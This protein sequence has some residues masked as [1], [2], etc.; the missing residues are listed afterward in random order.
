MSMRVLYTGTLL[1]LG[2]GYIFALLYVFASH[3][4]RDGQPGISVQDIIITY[5]GTT[6]GTQLESALRGPMSL[7]IQEDERAKVISWIR[8]GAEK[9]EYEVIIKPIIESECLACHDGRNPHLSNLDG[10]EN[11]E[12]VI[13]QDTGADLYSL[14][15]VSHIHLFG[16]TFIFFIMGLIFSHAYLRPVWFK[17]TVIVTPLVCIVADVSSWYITKLY[18]PFGWVVL[19]AGGFMG[20]S[21]AFMWF[22]SMYQMWFFK[23]PEDLRLRMNERVRVIG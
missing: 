9:S 20:L 18:N 22:V 11:M 19:V 21:F 5:S 14:V 15:R 16:L 13:D 12:D 7:M 8:G 10:Y 6:E 3:S 1:V 4:G 23:L 2:L 17:C